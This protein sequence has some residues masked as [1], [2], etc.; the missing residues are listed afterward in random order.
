M[1]IAVAANGTVY[2]GGWFNS[3][4]DAAGAAVVNTAY[5]AKWNPAGAGTW[6]ALGTGGVSAT[7][8]GVCA[9]ELDDPANPTRLYVGGDFSDIGTATSDNL[10]VWNIGAS[11]WSNVTGFGTRSIE[12][13]PEEILS[14]SPH[15]IYVASSNQ[16][17]NTLNYFAKYTTTGSA[18]TAVASG[19]SGKAFG[20]AKSGTDLY[21][22]G[23]FVSASATTQVNG[24]AKTPIASPSWTGL[25]AN[26]T[27]SAMPECNSSNS[28]KYCTEIAVH[29]ATGKVFVAGNFTKAQNN[30]VDVANSAGLAM[31]DPADGLWKGLGNIT[32]NTPVVEEVKVIGGYAYIGGRFDCVNGLRMNNMARY[33]I[34]AGTWEAV[35]DGTRAG[36]QVVANGAVRTIEPAP[37]GGALYVGGSFT[38]AGGLAAADNIAKLTPV[39]T[40]AGPCNPAA[41]GEVREVP[42][43][44]APKRFRWGSLGFTGQIPGYNN[45]E[46]GR[47]LSFQW[48]AP[49]GVNYYIYRVSTEIGGNTVA[50]LDCW[51]SGLTCDMVIPLDDPAWR[52]EAYIFKLQGFTFD[53]VGKSASL[54]VPSPYD[55]VFPPS[56]PRN[57]RSVGGWNKVTVSYDVPADEGTYS[58]TNYL[59]TSVPDR[60]ICITRVVDAN[61]LQCVFTSLTPGTN[62]RFTV[63]ALTGAGWGDQ[64]SVMTP[65]ASRNLKTTS[66]S[67]KKVTFLFG[68]FGGGSDITATVDAPGFTPGAQVTT[69]FKVGNAADWTKGPVL[70]VDKNGKVNLKQRFAK[71]ENGNPI[72]VRFQD[73]EGNFSN[74]VIIPKV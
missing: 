9:V 28:A 44:D 21:V 35:G 36:V 72:Q 74:T 15:E 67:R 12:A 58:I 73:A 70:K 65:V 5:V 7:L 14:V 69:W 29:D 26:P 11:T 18:V 16:L 1:D 63:Q 25:G 24:V 47:L 46:E 17:S 43:L 3:V 56:P 34:A 57:V 10:A 27:T 37:A 71:R 42:A 13:C 66:S 2:I 54:K 52:S 23:Q 41:A 8:Y 38:D 61:S 40:A 62:Y 50:G 55:P 31:W 45:G 53:G 51:S 22:T 48:D 20:L 68:L 6:S 33:D 32:G 4:N 19:F 60:R 30:G 59:V 64:A 49:V 39:A